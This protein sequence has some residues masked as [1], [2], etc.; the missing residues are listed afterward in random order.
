NVYHQDYKAHGEDTSIY[1]TL[2]GL[3]VVCGKNF[4]RQLDSWLTPGYLPACRAVGSGQ[5]RERAGK[6]H[7]YVFLDLA[8]HVGAGFIPARK[9]T[10]RGYKW[11]F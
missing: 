6:F 10:R 11:T 5:G 4:S 7:P 3:C 2:C 1:E 9:N 8:Y